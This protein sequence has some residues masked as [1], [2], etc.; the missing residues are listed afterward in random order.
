[1]I[2]VMIADD[3]DLLRED[4][5]E[6]INAQPDMQVVGTAASGAQIIDLAKTTRC[7][8]I[9]MDIEMENTNAGIAAAEVIR[10]RLPEA[11]NHLPHRT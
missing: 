6:L 1:M 11:D 7:D 5:S 10:E 4:M 2:S 9:L 8:I 3:F